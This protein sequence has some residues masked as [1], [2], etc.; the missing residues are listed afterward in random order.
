MSSSLPRLPAGFVNCCWRVLASS[1]AAACSSVVPDIGAAVGE[2]LRAARKVPLDPNV[3]AEA[4]IADL[5]ALPDETWLVLDDYQVLI[6]S[7][8]GLFVER[9]LAQSHIRA[10]IVSRRRPTLRALACPRASAT[11]LDDAPPSQRT[12]RCTGGSPGQ[13]QT[14]R[15]LQALNPMNRRNGS[16]RA[17]SAGS[18]PDATRVPPN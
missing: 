6:N 12:K 9:L 7:Q 2:R 4:L 13:R 3:L 1:I 8:C 17:T 14:M 16:Q 18:C 5:T 15:K 11:A 10:L